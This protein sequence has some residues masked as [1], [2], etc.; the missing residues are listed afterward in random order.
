M[1]AR[2]PASVR[3][4]IEPHSFCQ[5][6]GDL[7]ANRI[8]LHAF[9]CCSAADAGPFGLRSNH[10][11]WR[12]FGAKCPI[13]ARLPA[14][15]RRC[16]AASG[17][18]HCRGAEPPGCITTVVNVARLS[19]STVTAR[20]DSGSVAGLNVNGKVTVLPACSAVPP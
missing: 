9:P 4:Y 8:E 7:K 16:G 14:G 11:S 20:V 6:R 1:L 3:P 13:G 5:D 15:L 12:F 19:A 18:N 2:P 10:E 17:E